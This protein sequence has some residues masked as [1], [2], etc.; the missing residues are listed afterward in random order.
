MKETTMGKLKGG[1]AKFMAAKKA[2]AAAG[3][4]GG[5]SGGKKKG[6]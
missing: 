1:L 5:K 3:K 6:K 2:K 4:K